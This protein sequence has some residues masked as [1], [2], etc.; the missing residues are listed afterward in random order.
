MVTI[1]KI[2]VGT[3]P[4]GYCRITLFRYMLWYCWI[5]HSSASMLYRFFKALYTML[6]LTASFK[7]SIYTCKTWGWKKLGG[8]ICF[9]FSWM[10]KA[11][12]IFL[13]L[14]FLL[15]FMYFYLLQLDCHPLLNM[16]WFVFSFF[17]LSTKEPV[18]MINR[19]E[20]SK[21]FYMNL[22]SFV[23]LQ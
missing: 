13:L 14:C 6:I 22:W 1:V 16:N 5:S 2:R 4:Y 15:S 10:N 20:W 8:G 9:M 7:A 17:M 21:L 19:Y 18:L 12:C 23:E 3:I 11:L